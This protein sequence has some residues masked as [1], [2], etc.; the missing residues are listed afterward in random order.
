MK[1]FYFL[2]GFA[3]LIVAVGNFNIPSTPAQELQMIKKVSFG[4]MDLFGWL[5]AIVSTALLIPRDLED[6]T[7]YTILSK[8]VRRFDYLVGKLLGVLVLVGIS[9]LFMFGI[10]SAVLFVRE[11][12][13]VTAELTA[14]E[15]DPRYSQQDALAQASLIKQQGWRWELIYACWASFLKA[16]VVSSVTIFLSTFA[17][18][19][20][21][22]IITSI[23]LFLIGHA[24]TM[25]SQFFVSET[26]G[27]WFVSALSRIIRFI[28][29][30]YQLFSFSEGIVL[31]EPIVLIAIAK[32]SLIALAYIL[33]YLLLSTLV[34]FDKEF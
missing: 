6:R 31:G 28:I 3:I 27:N 34:F 18:S 21:F 16:A 2:L 33:V 19:S 11:F 14:L 12:F 13:Y 22:T 17:S 10:C 7:L 29:P 1:A 26:D 23:L 32:V 24:H 20:L 9:L 15:A 25:A 8:P 5:F 30:D 4:T